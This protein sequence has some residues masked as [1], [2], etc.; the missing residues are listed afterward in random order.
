VDSVTKEL[1]LLHSF[2]IKRRYI[3]CLRYIHNSHK[4][5]TLTNALLLT[6]CYAVLQKNSA[7]QGV[8]TCFSLIG[9]PTRAQC[10][11][12]ANHYN[13]ICPINST[14]FHSLSSKLPRVFIRLVLPG[15]EFQIRYILALHW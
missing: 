11:R 3:Q 4:L 1:Y 2:K 7:P 15:I 13:I 8:I 9:C 12:L 10:I 14:C 6:D 5:T